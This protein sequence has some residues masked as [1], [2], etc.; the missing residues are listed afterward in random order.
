MPA[1]HPRLGRAKLLCQ[2]KHD[3]E[4]WVLVE[5]QLAAGRDR[6]QAEVAVQ[7][8]VVKSQAGVMT[9]IVTCEGGRGNEAR[10]PIAGRI[11]LS[12]R[13]ELARA[14]GTSVLPGAVDEQL[15]GNRLVGPPAP[16]AREEDIAVAELRRPMNVPGRPRV[17]PDLQAVR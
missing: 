6:L 17:D 11:G 7:D 9:G 12:G 2:L 16:A 8:R 13:S 5:R 14:D 4:A 15:I 1:S 10:H 3:P